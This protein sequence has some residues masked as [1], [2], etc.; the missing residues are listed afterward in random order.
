MRLAFSWPLLLAVAAA[1]QEPVCNGRLVRRKIKM[2]RD[3]NLERFGY[4]DTVETLPQGLNVTARRSVIS[5][6]QSSNNDAVVTNYKGHGKVLIIN[7]GVDDG[8]VNP[9]FRGKKA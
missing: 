5:A 4:G 8:V 2:E 1:Q 7:D 3:G 6:V 9:N